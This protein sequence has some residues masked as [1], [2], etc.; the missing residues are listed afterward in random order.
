MTYGGYTQ[1]QAVLPGNQSGNGYVIPASPEED[2]SGQGVT[3]YF[4]QVAGRTSGAV[5]YLLAAETPITAT[6]H[7]GPLAFMAGNSACSPMSIETW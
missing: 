2:S 7:S 4:N 1:N 5:L 3:Q 6:S